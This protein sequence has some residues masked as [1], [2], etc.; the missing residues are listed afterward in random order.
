MV[1]CYFVYACP[2]RNPSAG[3]TYLCQDDSGNRLIGSKVARS[4]YETGGWSVARAIAGNRPL[5]MVEPP[6]EN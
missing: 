3:L 4:K 5:L 6:K 2:E 1:G